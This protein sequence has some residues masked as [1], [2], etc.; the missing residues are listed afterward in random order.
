MRGFWIGDRIC[1]ERNPS[2]SF[3][4]DTTSGLLAQEVVEP[5]TPA[6]WLETEY[7]N[8]VF[9]N[10]VTVTVVGA[11]IVSR[12]STTTHDAKGKFATGNS[13]ALGQNES[14]QYHARFGQPYRPQQPDHDLE[15]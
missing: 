5:N 12:S 8:D 1:G 10:K 11:D 6:L 3:A 13:N 15:L 14:Y 2:S 7:V 4:Y 9:G